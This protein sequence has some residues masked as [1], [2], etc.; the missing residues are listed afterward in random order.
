[1]RT[2]DISVHGAAENH[3]QEVKKTNRLKP[4]M[5]IPLNEKFYN[6]IQYIAERILSNYNRR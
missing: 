2:R 3:F 5:N 4:F 6:Q 1:M